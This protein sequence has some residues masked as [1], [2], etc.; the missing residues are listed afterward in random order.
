MI[1]LEILKEMSHEDL[2]SIGILR[3]G[4]RHKILKQLG[5]VQP[6]TN[7]TETLTQNVVES[8]LLTE[9]P[10]EITLGCNNCEET[11][12]TLENLNAHNLSHFA[13]GNIFQDSE[14]FVQSVSTINVEHCAE[15]TRLGETMYRCEN[16]K[17]STKEIDNIQR[18]K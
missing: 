15:S 3:F 5:K 2:K 12:Q 11:F 9:E 17:Y 6:Q 14:R 4:Q 10:L 1:T 8:L 13:R 7:R 16:C 18:K